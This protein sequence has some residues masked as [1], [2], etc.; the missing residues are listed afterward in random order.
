[1]KKASDPLTA[2]KFP[3]PSN[4]SNWVM[5]A[6]WANRLILRISKNR[7]SGFGVINYIENKIRRKII[8]S[9]YI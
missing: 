7:S 9:D 2:S 1:M 5:Q 6:A 3:S 4:G 8:K